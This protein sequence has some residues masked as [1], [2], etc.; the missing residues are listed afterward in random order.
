MRT[1]LCIPI[2]RG[3]RDKIA[4]LSQELRSQIDTHASWVAPENYHITVRF[5]GDIAPMLTVD[6]ERACREITVGTPAFSVPIDR[7][8][9]FPSLDQPR[10]VWVGGEAVPPFRR[11]LSKI[12]DALIPLGFPQSREET[13]AHV[14]LARI[15]GRIRPSFD[16][17]M[18]GLGRKI[19]WNLR[20]DR[21]VLME[22]KLTSRGA[23]YY[24]LFTLPLAG[25]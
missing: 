10:V 1:F 13:F 15:K 6:L 22:S 9:A 7:V 4:E 14:T 8:G 24:P 21:L 11:L 17:S 19:A 12:G 25:E 23:V 2:D 20:A 16:A 5:L 18:A 3:H